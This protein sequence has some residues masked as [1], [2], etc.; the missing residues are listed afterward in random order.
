ML[1]KMALVHNDSSPPFSINVS[2]QHTKRKCHRKTQ[3]KPGE[4]EEREKK[5]EKKKKEK[6][7]GRRRNP[8]N[9]VWEQN[10]MTKQFALPTFPRFYWSVRHQRPPSIR[11]WALTE[12]RV[13][14]KWHAL[15]RAGVASARGVFA[16]ANSFCWYYRGV[17][18]AWTVCQQCW[19]RN[20]HCRTKRSSTIAAL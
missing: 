4:R 6:K 16:R 10:V 3:R 1:F 5:K 20:C 13:Q 14:D 9:E 7:R 2:A 18:R 8:V 19:F 15:P 12:A 11:H 17:W